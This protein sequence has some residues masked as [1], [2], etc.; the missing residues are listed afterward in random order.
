[1]YIYT[2]DLVGVFAFAVFGSY[3]ALEKG[4]NAYGVITCAALTALGG[5]T[6]R[7][8]ILRHLPIYFTNHT[9]LYVTL[10]AA[11]LTIVVHEHFSKVRRY[12]LVI[13]A[14]GLAAFAFIGA[15]KADMAGLGLVGMVFFAIL[16][17]AGGGILTDIVTGDKPSPFS[18]E[19]YVF[20][21]ALGGSLYWLIDAHRATFIATAIVL[22]VPFAIRTGWLAQRGEF[23]FLQALASK[24]AVLVHIVPALPYRTRPRAVIAAL[25]I[26]ESAY[27]PTMPPKSRNS[28]RTA[29]SSIRTSLAIWHAS[30]KRRPA[31]SAIR[32]ATSDADISIRSRRPQPHAHSVLMKVAR[33]R[34][35][36]DGRETGV[37]VR[38]Y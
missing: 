33:R 26:R 7:E 34:P 14:I 23:G 1:M 22:A 9:Y 5:G 16:T 38:L 2:L 36:T 3:K 32:V 8:L 37:V 18:D 21:A 35:E 25:P 24:F 17:A 31:S 12:V 10:A 6:I 4:F 20:P 15:R 30:G 19:L 28:A 13:D 29:V 27:S 11:V